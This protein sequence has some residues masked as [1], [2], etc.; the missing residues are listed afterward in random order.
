MRGT[1]VRARCL[2]Q[3][4]S[5]PRLRYAQTQFERGSEMAFCIAADERARDPSP[6]PSSC[7]AVPTTGS[8]R[9]RMLCCFVCARTPPSSP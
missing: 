7:G 2:Q 9:M 3:R 4:S 5:R 6:P 1:C 8:A